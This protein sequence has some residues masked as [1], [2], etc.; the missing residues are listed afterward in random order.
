MR[1]RWRSYTRTC[2]N[3]TPPS[4]RHGPTGR[5]APCPGMGFR[6]RSEVRPPFVRST[7]RYDRGRDAGHGDRERGPA[8]EV[9]QRR[10]RERADQQDDEA[11]KETG[12]GECTGWW[13]APSYPTSAKGHGSTVNP[14]RRKA[15]AGRWSADGSFRRWVHRLATYTVAS[16]G[17]TD[18]LR[19]VGV[20]VARCHEPRVTNRRRP[21]RLRIPAGRLLHELGH[22]RCR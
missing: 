11:Q 10:R 21:A 17:Q 18:T 12:L 7:P 1:A 6:A 13:V 8:H 2:S 22:A 5:R 19:H 9:V 14:E 15:L 16:V 3:A 4:R 20:L